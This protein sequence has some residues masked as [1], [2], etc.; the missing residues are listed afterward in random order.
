[1]GAI[2]EDVA[3]VGGSSRHRYQRR[4]LVDRDASVVGLQLAYAA[5]GAAMVLNDVGHAAH[6]VA[7]QAREDPPFA[8]GPFAQ[9]RVLALDEVTMSIDSG[10][11]SRRSGPNG[12]GKRPRCAGSGVG[13]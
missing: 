5:I 7:D 11:S 4:P 9:V 10:R 8:I 13:R 1:M 6:A 12:P 2:L 3:A